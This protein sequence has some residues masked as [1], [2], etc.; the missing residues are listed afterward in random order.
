MVQTIVSKSEKVLVAVGGKYQ[1]R[2]KGVMILI[3]R[4]PTGNRSR[5]SYKLR[6]TLGDNPAHHL[7]L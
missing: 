3:R 2:R 6:R 1:Q 7:I 4:S 5:R